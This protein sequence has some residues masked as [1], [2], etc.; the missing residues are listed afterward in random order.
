MTTASTRQREL[1]ELSPLIHQAL[2]D[3]F[4]EEEALFNLCDAG[5]ML[6][7]G[8]LCTSLCHLERVRDR[9]GPSGRLR[10]IAVVAFPFGTIPAELKRAQAEWA[11]ARGADALDVVP[12]FAALMAGR[13]ETYAEELAQICDLG[14]PV[15]VILDVNRLPPDRLSLATEA[16]IDSGASC[17]QA[18]NGF[19]AAT[20]PI[21]V[22]KLK[23]LARGRCAIKAAGG[24]QRLETALEL[25]EEG[26]TALGTS[27][28]PKLIQALRHPQ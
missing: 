28:G 23:E 16:A 13:A 6:S 24:I 1:P 27:H 7:F 5:R 21:Q 25:V 9:I 15:T 18:G 19:G 11:A 2:L 17:L 20:T 22:R 26:A 14:L 8:A 3:P 4:L 10:L 12:D